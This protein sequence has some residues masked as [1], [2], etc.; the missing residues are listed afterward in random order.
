[1]ARLSLADLR[2]PLPEFDPE[3]APPGAD[4]RKRFETAADAE[5]EDRTRIK[6][7][8]RQGR[9]HSR[10]GSRPIKRIHLAD[11]M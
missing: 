1:M 7:L 4:G 6:L 3:L 5:A 2:L 11:G 8:R 10:L 9:K